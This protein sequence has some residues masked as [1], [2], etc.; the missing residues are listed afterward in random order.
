MRARKDPHQLEAAAVPRPSQKRAH[1]TWTGVGKGTYTCPLFPFQGVP[2]WP[3]HVC[4]HRLH[5]M[6]LHAHSG[7]RDI[8]CVIHL[9]ITPQKI[10]PPFTRPPTRL[11]LTGWNSAQPRYSLGNVLLTSKYFPP[12]SGNVA[13]QPTSDILWGS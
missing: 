2:Q 5:R 12:P 1:H 6:S 11:E 10:P 7:T 9:R 4:G 13:Y 8:Q 3:A